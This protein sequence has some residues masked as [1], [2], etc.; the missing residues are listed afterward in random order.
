MK[1]EL[2]KKYKYDNEYKFQLV[3]WKK[4][5]FVFF[6][7]SYLTLGVDFTVDFETGLYFYDACL[8]L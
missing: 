3:K 7:N 8:K 1:I 5:F 6:Y 2:Q 4:L